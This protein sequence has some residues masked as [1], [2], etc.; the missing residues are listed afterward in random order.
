MRITC[1]RPL[2]SGIVAAGLAASSH[3]AVI[4]TYTFDNTNGVND[5]P[6]D[7][8]I[9][10][11][12]ANATFSAFQ[13]VG[14]SENEQGRG[15]SSA[16]TLAT[17][18]SGLPGQWSQDNQSFSA[19]DYVGFTLTADVGYEIDLAELSLDYGQANGFTGDSTFS[20]RDLSVLIRTS[21]TGL[22]TEVI[23]EDN[24][25]LDA[26]SFATFTA[27]LT[28]L[29]NTSF[30]EV[31]IRVSDQ[32]A[33]RLARFDNVQVDAGVQLIPEPA[34]VALIGLAGLVIFSRRRAA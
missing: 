32:D 12:P 19:T 29:A 23:N 27:D 10:A 25:M 33:D 5:A 30:L 2:L 24:I 26:N 20:P 18:G 11:Q 1:W 31:R 28:G 13:V 21:P 9:D 6:A 15:A 14:V 34:S 7:K 16:N 22:F 8:T 3:A 4:G 17:G